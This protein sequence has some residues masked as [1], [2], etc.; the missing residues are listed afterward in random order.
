M[1]TLPKPKKIRIAFVK[2]GGLAVGGSEMWLQ[3][4]AANLPQD[5]FDV[6]YFYSDIAPLIGTDYTHTDT[7]IHRLKYMRDHNVN[8]IKFHIDAVDYR[9]HYHPW[10]GTNFW[11]IF[12]PRKY[13]L[14]QTIKAG[15]K[16]YP[17]YLI[18]LP[19]VEIVA[20]ANRPD[21]SKNIAWSFHSS[22]WQRNVWL[23]KGG[24]EKRSSVL[25]APLDR[26]LTAEN[27][28]AELGISNDAVI[29]GFHQRADDNIWSPI[30]LNAFS[31]LQKVNENPNW[32]FFMKGGGEKYR[33]QAKELGLKNVYFLPADGDNVGTS[34]FLNTLDIFAHGRG[35][36]ETFGAVFVEAMIHG[37]P[38]LSHHSQ[39]GLDAQKETMGKAGLFASDEEDYTKKLLALF[40]NKSL[41]ETLAKEA[42]KNSTE[43]SIEN[44]VKNVMAVYEEVLKDPGRFKIKINKLTKIRDFIYSYAI[45]I[46]KYVKHYF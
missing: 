45:F 14:I 23:K 25:P 36:G 24:S 35:D 39:T 40:S 22:P 3:K 15:P 26:Q 42:V 29:A 4:M 8:L 44:T 46:I 16:E 28:R 5:L 2:F 12:D 19:I 21:K 38:C 34:K 41:R 32:H 11:Q 10:I 1:A 37:K 6:D 30:P 43:Y 33:K 13:D 17:F 20:L 31:K 18:D 9:F 7:D 27:Y